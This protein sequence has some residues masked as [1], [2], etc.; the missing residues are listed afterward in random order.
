MLTP[1]IIEG[2]DRG[3]DVLV[4]L[5]QEARVRLTPWFGVT[6]FLDAGNAFERWQDVSWSSLKVGI[7]AGLRVTTPLGVVRLDL[8][9]PR[10]RPANHPSAIWYFSFGHAF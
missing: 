4:V 1:E 5:N 8:G 2:L 7:G 3:G 10:P 9:F 6:G